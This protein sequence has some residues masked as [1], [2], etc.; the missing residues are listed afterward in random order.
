MTRK[1]TSGW[2]NAGDPS[3]AFFEYVF[4]VLK[5]L[6]YSVRAAYYE[7]AVERLRPVPMLHHEGIGR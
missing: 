4:R 2:G 5:N 1:P 6:A 3:R 7:E